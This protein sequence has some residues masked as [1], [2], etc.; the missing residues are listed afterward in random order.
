MEYVFENKKNFL[1]KTV[2]LSGIKDDQNNYYNGNTKI[3]DI[4][5]LDSDRKIVID[6]FKNIKYLYL[7]IEKRHFQAYQNKQLIENLN[8]KINNLSYN[9]QKLLLKRKTPLKFCNSNLINLSDQKLTMEELEYMLNSF[10]GSNRER[11]D[12]ETKIKIA[13]EFNN[14]INNDLNDIENDKLRYINEKQ[15]LV[16]ENNI[17]PILTQNRVN[18]CFLTH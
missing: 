12:L 3:V 16:V 2:T 4:K 1:G 5:F 8:V 10:E 6:N 15:K 17:N 14:S 11:S 18:G 7:T 9:I 13:T